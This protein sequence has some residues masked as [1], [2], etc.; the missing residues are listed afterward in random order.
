MKKFYTSIFIL[1]CFHLGFSQAPANPAIAKVDDI[2]TAI[3]DITGALYKKLENTKTGNYLDVL[4]RLYQMTT[5]N[6][7]GAQKSIAFNGTLFAI[8]AEA[9]PDLRIDRNF[10]KE[11]F[12]RNFEFNF[13]L[14]LNEDYKYT[15]FTGG[16]TYAIING[17]DNKAVKFHDVTLLN[18][19]KKLNADIDAD[20]N[21]YIDSI[22]R[23]PNGNLPT[24]LLQIQE[25]LDTLHRYGK[26]NKFPAGFMPK[27]NTR[28]DSSMVAFKRLMDEA[29]DEIAKAPLLTFSAN[30]VADDKGNISSG[31]L[32]LVFL[33]GN[34]FGKR[35]PSELDIRSTFAYGDTLVT[36]TLRR[37]TLKSTLGFNFVLLKSKTESKSLV[38]FKAYAEYDNVFKDLLPDEKRNTFLANGDLR[39]R[40][41]DALWLPLTIKYDVEKSSFLGFLNISYNF[42]SVSGKSP[43]SP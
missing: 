13:D 2:N 7:T 24:I 3:S 19:Y 22:T 26:T 34:L 17:R 6:L 10:I 4:S 30:G 16:F 35:A 42:D 18:A 32:G 28:L 8:K 20:A 36:A 25:G 5:H 39:L 12:S 27:L 1:L 43:G 38:E 14:N 21:K 37:T 31:R 29:Y 9:D 15:G 33:K 23:N 11:K 41:T 40:I